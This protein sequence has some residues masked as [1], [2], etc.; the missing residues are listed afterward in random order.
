MILGSVHHAM[1]K[2]KKIADTIMNVDSSVPNENRQA[3]K[4]SIHI[5]II[6]IVQPLKGWRGL[7]N[8]RGTDLTFV[9]SFTERSQPQLVQVSVPSGS[10]VLQRGQIIIIFSSFEWIWVSRDI[11][12]ISIHIRT[13]RNGGIGPRWGESWNRARCDSSDKSQFLSRVN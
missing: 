1:R 3:I 5:S 6:A 7:A 12:F 9:P 13:A 11:C 4:N 10:I 2:H 8:E